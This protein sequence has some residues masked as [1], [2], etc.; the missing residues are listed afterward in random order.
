MVS[1]LATVGEAEV[2]G[3]ELK[4]FTH[5]LYEIEKGF[6]RLLSIPSPNPA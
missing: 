2:N 5:M 6:V 3:G 1:G 4:V